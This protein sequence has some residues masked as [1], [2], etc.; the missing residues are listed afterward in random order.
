MQCRKHIKAITIVSFVSGHIS[1]SLTESV[2]N[3]T[4]L[5]YYG[6]PFGIP[7]GDFEIGKLESQS[8]CLLVGTEE[9]KND[10]EYCRVSTT[11]AVGIFEKV[12]TQI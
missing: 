5:Y 1:I 4:E 3:S 6:I 8:A 12:Q 2:V 7:F 11:V 10:Y 9:H